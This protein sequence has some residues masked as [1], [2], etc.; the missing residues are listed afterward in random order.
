MSRKPTLGVVVG[1]FQ[2][3]NLHRGHHHL[4]ETALNHSDETLVVLGS[5]RSLPTAKNPLPFSARRQMVLETFPEVAV[6]EQFDHPS[7]ATWSQ[8]LD[9]Q[10]ATRYPKHEVTLYGSRDSFIPHYHGR[11]KTKLIK[12][13]SAPSGSDLRLQLQTEPLKSAD[14]RSGLIFALATRLPVAYQV[15][16]IAIIKEETG[17]ILLGQKAT[18]QGKWRFIGGFVD[19]SVDTTLEGAARREAYEETGGLE[20][21]PAIYQGSAIIPDWRYKGGPDVIMSAFF[22]AKYCFGSPVAS[23][24]IAALKWFKLTEVADIIHENHRPLLSLLNPSAS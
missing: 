10:I 5:S 21:G 14:F 22:K 16:D 20:I 12:S 19:A 9:E 17:E 23:D 24:D 7:D 8:I 1:R 2:V 13:V 18:D 15:V 3:P 6:I 4:I 11:F